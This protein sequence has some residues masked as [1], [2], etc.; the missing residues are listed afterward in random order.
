MRESYIKR[1][2]YLDRIKPFIGKQII[3]VITGQRGISPVILLF[4][5][6]LYN[7]TIKPQ[8]NCQIKLNMASNVSGISIFV[9]K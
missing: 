5:F 7:V 1:P 3:K 8:I 6:L 2:V 9:M 4:T